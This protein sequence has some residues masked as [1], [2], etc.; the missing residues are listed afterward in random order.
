MKS[1]MPRLLQ[2]TMIV[3]ALVTAGCGGTEMSGNQS[4]QEEALTVAP[5]DAGTAV[6]AKTCVAGKKYGSCTCQANGNG[7]VCGLHTCMNCDPDQTPDGPN[8]ACHCDVDSA[9]PVAPAAAKPA[10]QCLPDFF[11][12][13]NCM[14]E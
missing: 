11:H 8:L 3:L 7:V 1:A 4:S 6:P 14:R 2:G 13:P 12:Q 5:V 9:V 10:V